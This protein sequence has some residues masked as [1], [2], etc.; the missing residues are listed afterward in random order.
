MHVSSKE[1]IKKN[2]TALSGVCE[3]IG[4]EGI[5]DSNGED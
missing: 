5:Y 4:E 1:E 2:T 3:V